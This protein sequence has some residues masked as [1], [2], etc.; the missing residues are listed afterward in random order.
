M[1]E[2]RRS[3]GCLTFN[4]GIS[5]LVRRHL[6]IETAP[7]TLLQ[8][9]CWSQGAHCTNYVSIQVKSTGTMLCILIFAGYQMKAT[10]S[11]WLYLI[12]N[13]VLKFGSAEWY[14]TRISIHIF[15]KYIRVLKLIPHIGLSKIV[16]SGRRHHGLCR[17]WQRICHLL[18]CGCM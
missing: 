12:G 8:L 13:I 14:F 5:I 16:V 6:Y 18:C 9:L 7:R 15:V 10:P 4:M 3:W 11:S 1:L 2:I 17:H